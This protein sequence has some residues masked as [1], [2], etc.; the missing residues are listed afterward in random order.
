[1]DSLTNV[2]SEF[3]ISKVSST[4]SPNVLILA[5]KID[6]LFSKNTLA[7]MARR[8]D[9]SEVSIVIKFL[10]LSLLIDSVILIFFSKL[11]FIFTIFCFFEI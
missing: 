5:E 3:S 9:L 2:L 10:R 8:P 4:L 11:F 6:I 1:M 7:I